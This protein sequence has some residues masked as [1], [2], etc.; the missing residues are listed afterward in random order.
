M[1]VLYHALTDA[2]V[3]KA[4]L[5]EWGERLGNPKIA[6]L[7]LRSGMHVITES[8]H[9]QSYKFLWDLLLDQHPHGEWA[10]GKWEGLGD[11][12]TDVFPH[13]LLVELF[14]KQPTTLIL[15]EYQTWFDGESAWVPPIDMVL[16]TAHGRHRFVLGQRKWKAQGGYPTLTHC[17]LSILEVA[18]PFIEISRAEAT[19]GT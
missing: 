3:T 12:K 2:P 13:K 10:R 8:L 19:R 17:G 14:Q 16:D 18:V 6:G 9:R 5:R 1:G 4:W 11:R 7:P 15:D